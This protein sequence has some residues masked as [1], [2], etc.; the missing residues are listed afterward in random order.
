MSGLISSI[1]AQILCR[2]SSKLF[3]ET[4]FEGKFVIFSKKLCI[5]RYHFF[6]GHR[7]PSMKVHQKERKKVGVVI[8]KNVCDVIVQN[9]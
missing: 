1:L 6:F 8:K 7:L 2:K 9:G 3:F 4:I 5:M